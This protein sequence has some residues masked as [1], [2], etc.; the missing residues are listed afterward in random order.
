MWLLHYSPQKDIDIDVNDDIVEVN[1][2]YV[3]I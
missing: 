3:S 1:R 2:Y